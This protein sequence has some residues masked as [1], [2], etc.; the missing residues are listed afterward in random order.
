MSE[1]DNDIYIDGVQFSEN[2]ETLIKFPKD[3]DVTSYTIPE[4][5]EIIDY[6]A[7]ENCTQLKEVIFPEGLKEIHQCSFVHCNN[8][9]SV[10]LPSSLIHIGDWT[11]GS[12]S[13]LKE[14]FVPA[15][16]EDWAK[17]EFGDRFDQIVH[18]EITEKD[19][20]NAVETIKRNIEKDSENIVYN[21]SECLQKDERVKSAIYDYVSKEYNL[22]T[23]EKEILNNSSDFYNQTQEFVKKRFNYI[24]GV[25]FTSDMKT[26]IESPP[27]KH[28]ESFSIPEGVTEIK[29]MAF[30]Y[31]RNLKEIIIPDS[32][33]KIGYPCFHYCK[34]LESVIIPPHLEDWAKQEFGDKFNE[35]VKIRTTEQDNSKDKYN[36]EDLKT[37]RKEDK[38]II[39]FHSYAKTIETGEN[40]EPYIA[41]Y[42]LTKG[43]TVIGDY[44]Y[45]HCYFLKEIRIP[46]NIEKIGNF[47]FDACINL[48]SVTIPSTVKEIGEKVF[49]GCHN[50]KEVTI[51]PYLE[52]WAKEEFGDRFDQIVHINITE[53]D[54]NNTI[55]TITENI[56][57]GN[58]ITEN[59][60]QCMFDKTEVREA[61]AKNLN[62]SEE[63]HKDLMSN[64]S[65]EEFVNQAK[66]YFMYENTAEKDLSAE[67][68][69]R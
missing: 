51:S 62:L 30:G 20:N 47:A 14:I 63:E 3:K 60:P 48:E 13:K 64:I 43:D 38:T 46:S 23:E 25:K 35:I 52:S 67:L 36:I 32:V 31:N 58:N 66:L 68:D 22:T 44:G 42:N 12:C 4:G 40:I 59:I 29:K 27:H 54:I 19:I 8:L 17:K 7:F 5:V 56:E 10:R 57:N 55:Q 53:K 28:I 16:L 11:F 45:S 49:N 34:Q 50:L 6:Y 1:K 21:V 24:D 65:N 26:L 2:M 61:M 69:D 15:D 37:Q 18:M 41:D 33:E 9:E 39:P